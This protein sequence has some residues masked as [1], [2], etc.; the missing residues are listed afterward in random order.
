MSIPLTTNEQKSGAALSV[1]KSLAWAYGAQIV[2]AAA[3]F[4]GAVI[5]ARLLSPAETG[6]YAFA[7]AASGAIAIIAN[8]GVS[9]FVIRERNVDNQLLTTAFTVNAV[10][11]SMLSAVIILTSFIL[12][13]FIRADGVGNVLRV[14]AIVPLIGIFDFRPGVMLQRDMALRT[15]SLISMLGSL[16]GLF[17]TLAFALSGFS[18]MSMAYAL[19]IQNSLATL[20]NNVAGRRHA[21]FGISLK[22]ARKIIVF[23]LRMMSVSGVATL[24]Q[25]SSDLIMGKTLGVPTLGIYSRATGLS[26]TIFFN[27]YGTATRVVFLQLSREY[28]ETGELGKPYIRGLE[29]ILAFM[30]PLLCGVAI[31]SRP[32]IRLL[33][34]AN[35]DGAAVPLSLLMISQVFTLTFG[36][37][38]EIYV[39]RDETRNQTKYEVTR[40]IIGT[41]IFSIGCLFNVVAATLG[42][43]AESLIGS[44]FYFGKMSKLAGVAPSRLAGVYVR[45]AAL[46]FAT[47]TPALL[48]MIFFNWSPTT[49]LQTVSASVGIGIIAWLLVI[50]R[51]KHP[52]FHELVLLCD[53]VKR[54]A[55]GTA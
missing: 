37:N 46:T 11:N 47:I 30:W 31:L 26:N 27:I 35:W 52:L 34:G 3:G 55:L 40:T 42:R 17:A 21:S 44:L 53:F 33:Y 23:G 36:M 8:F 32:A 5:L 20:L 19:L 54:K 38:W 18:Y 24:A 14:I 2:S 6:V 12:G 41:V 7:V 22:G 15:T 43:V 1:R 45:S 29:L 25:R 10:V 4:T 48:T 16:A 28:R 13:E 51:M 9:S 50:W 49:P 39:L